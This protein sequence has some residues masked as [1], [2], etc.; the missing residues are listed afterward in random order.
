M[1]GHTS[2]FCMDYSGLLADAAQAE[3]LLKDPLFELQICSGAN[4]EAELVPDPLVARVISQ[5][6]KF[7]VS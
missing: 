5:P 4:L 3:G 2:T 7:L 6:L 1:Q